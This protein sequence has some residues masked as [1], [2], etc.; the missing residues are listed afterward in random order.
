MGWGLLLIIMVSC[1]SEDYDTGDGEYSY[2]IGEFGQV[3][4]DGEAQI[5]RMVTDNG[6]EVT[7]AQPF[8]REWAAT[9]DSLYRAYVQYERRMDSNGRYRLFGIAQ[10]MV[11]AFREQADMKEEMKS[12]PVEWESMWVSHDRRYLNLS[13]QL[14]VGSTGEEQLLQ[15][16][17]L[18]RMSAVVRDD[19][20]TVHTLRFFHDQNGVPQYYRSAVYASIPLA[21]LHE[22]DELVLTI[23]T[24]Q[25]DMT[26]RYTVP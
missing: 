25:G 15:R 18:V 5:T 24:Y 11:L 6:D 19:G 12:D 21:A 22:G 26:R 23:P 17:G 13:L 1:T 8:K 10:V 2:L 3:Y 4:T 14:M 7:F 16:I 20:T 9:P